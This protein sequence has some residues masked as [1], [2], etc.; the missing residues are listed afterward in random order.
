MCIRDS[1]SEPR[2]SWD[3][4]QHGCAMGELVA[5]IAA[6]FLSTELG[7]PQSLDNHAAHLNSWLREMR[8]DPAFIFRASTQASKVTD[9]LLSFVEEEAVIPEVVAV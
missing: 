4:Q 5:E 8:N 2:L 9:Y 1:W 3:S 7:V 6:S